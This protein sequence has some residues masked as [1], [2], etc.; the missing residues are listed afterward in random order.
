MES[1]DEGGTDEVEK[2]G[3]DIELDISGPNSLEL[4]GELGFVDILGLIHNDPRPDEMRQ[5]AG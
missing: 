3:L 1:G 4:L 5:D 2:I